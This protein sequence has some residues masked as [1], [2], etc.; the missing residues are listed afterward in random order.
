AYRERAGDKG[1]LGVQVVDW[2][3]ALNQKWS[4]LR[5][6]EVKAETDGEEHVFEVQ[7]YLGE[8]DPKAVRIEL[9]ADG[10]M[11]GAPTRQ[12]MKCVRQLTGAS[13]GYVYTASMSAARQPADY[14]ARVIPHREGVAIPLE[15][16]RVV[17]QR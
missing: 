5:F 6:G 17:W 7:V 14:T 8:L 12:E 15:D 16:A 3:H 2:R 10:V 1:A 11:G 4:A 9:Y 13:S